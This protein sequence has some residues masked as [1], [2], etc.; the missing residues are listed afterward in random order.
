MPLSFL[1]HGLVGFFPPCGHMRFSAARAGFVVLPASRQRTFC[2]HCSTQD[3]PIPPLKPEPQTLTWLSFPEDGVRPFFPSLAAC[4]SAGSLHPS[5]PSCLCSLY[6]TIPPGC[7]FFSRDRYSIKSA[8]AIMDQ[9]P[10]PGKQFLMFPSFPHKHFP[11]WCFQVI[12][13]SSFFHRRGPS[14]PLRTYWIDVLRAASAGFGLRTGLVTPSMILAGVSPFSCI[15]P[16]WLKNIPFPFSYGCDEP[17]LNQTGRY[18]PGTPL[19]KDPFLF[20]LPATRLVP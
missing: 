12:P 5:P 18:P 1:P 7:A 20:V 11:A 17:S 9:S 3:S 19:R 4:F 16:G 14:E 2:L 10:S 15:A 13:V 6:R 8:P